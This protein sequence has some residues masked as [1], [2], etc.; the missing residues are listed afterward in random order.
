MKK[1]LQV[2]QVYGIESSFVVDPIKRIG[3]L[4]FIQVAILSHSSDVMYEYD[5]NDV[6]KVEV[7]SNNEHVE[8]TKISDDYYI[9]RIVGVSNPCSMNPGLERDCFEC[10]CVE[11]SVHQGYED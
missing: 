4:K 10:H 5:D 2:S 9:A 7:V 6:D 11:C 8:V 3:M 1:Q